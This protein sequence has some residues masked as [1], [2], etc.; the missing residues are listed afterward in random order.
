[1]HHAYTWVLCPWVFIPTWAA[2][3]RLAAGGS[4]SARQKGDPFYNADAQRV[5]CELLIGI[6]CMS[7]VLYSKILR[8][9]RT[10][11][12]TSTILRYNSTRGACDRHAS[13]LS[14]GVYRAEGG[15]ERVNL[16]FVQ[17]GKL[18]GGVILYRCA[19]PLLTVVSTGQGGHRFKS[20]RRARTW[21]LPL[22]EK[23]YTRTYSVALCGWYGGLSW[24]TIMASLLACVLG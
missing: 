7:N 13:N 10:A 9:A 22:Y 21:I 11:N 14:Q 24:G 17:T 18:R 1:M 4:N 5:Q 2:S 12:A 3:W 20:T 23:W 19:I 8:T 6:Y 16:A 15:K